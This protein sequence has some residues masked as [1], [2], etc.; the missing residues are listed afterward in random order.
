MD[1]LSRG[2]IFSPESQG[3]RRWYDQEN[4]IKNSLDGFASLDK[5]VEA[6]QFAFENKEP[7]SAWIVLSHYFL[8]RQGKCY[9]LRDIDVEL[10]DV[11]SEI[12]EEITYSMADIRPKNTIMCVDCKK[13][14]S[15]REFATSRMVQKNAILSLDEYAGLSLRQIAPLLRTRTDGIYQFWEKTCQRNLPKT[16]EWQTVGQDYIVEAGD[17]FELSFIGY[18]HHACNKQKKSEQSKNE[19]LNVFIKAGFSGFKF[20]E[21]PNQYCSRDCCAPWQHVE[22][23]IGDI[24]IGWRKR[25]ISIEWGS[26][27]KDFS[28]LFTNEETT[29]WETGIHAWGADKAVEYLKKV[30]EACQGLC[31]QR[32]QL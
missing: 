22:T 15:L 3:T 2:F 10:P 14:I 6:R 21:I 19:F 13:N 20:K 23:E 18:S 29:K 25:V 30:R 16:I 7:L 17:E 5:L 11:T 8:D 27:G 1:M 4:G 9:F 26:L 28:D 12:P 32:Q 24:I 31:Y